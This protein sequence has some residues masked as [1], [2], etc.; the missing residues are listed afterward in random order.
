[1]AQGTLLL[2]IPDATVHQLKPATTNNSSD[3]SID[4][5]LLTA[6]ILNLLLVDIPSTALKSIPSVSE[7]PPYNNLEKTNGEP[8]Q[9]QQATVETWLVLSLAD[10]LIDIPLSQSSQI[11]F[12]QPRSY[13]V[14]ILPGDATPAEVDKK[15]GH[16]ALVRIDIASHIPDDTIDTLDSILAGWTQYPGRQSANQ[17]LLSANHIPSKSH[18]PP[19]PS[20]PSGSS[21]FPKEKLG[22]SQFPA[23]GASSK[24]CSLFYFFY[25]SYP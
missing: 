20:H 6:T 7:P 11:S 12:Q 23:N 22:A 24:V 2:S 13:L 8:Q 14:P 10:G 3:Q 17:N 25:S 4:S 19:P 1:M 9:A 21:S 18:S 15:N 16:Q 5:T